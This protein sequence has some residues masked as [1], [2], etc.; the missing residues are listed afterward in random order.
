MLP[1]GL[2]LSSPP[3]MPTCC[4]ITKNECGVTSDFGGA[5]KRA[6]F[7]ALLVAQIDEVEANRLRRGQI[8]ERLIEEPDGQ[9]RLVGAR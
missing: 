1:C 4:L 6:R 5:S 9:Q 8:G 7:R 2:P 3:A